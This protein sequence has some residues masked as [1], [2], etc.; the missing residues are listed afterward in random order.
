M[1]DTVQYASRMM[2]D[3]STET[4][5]KEHRRDGI[6]NCGT[7]W[8][9]ATR[10]KKFA[11]R[12]QWPDKDND[13]V[14]QPN[15][16]SPRMTIPETSR[17]LA[18]FSGR[19]MMQR[20]EREYIPRNQDVARWAETLTKVDRAIMGACDAEQ[21]DSAAF[22]DGPG[23]QGV[24]WV[25]W[26]VD[27][28]SGEN[29]QIK[30]ETVPIWS[31]LWPATREINLRDRAWQRWGS[32]WP[33]QTVKD[34]WPKKYDQIVTMIGSKPW[35]AAEQN[36]GQSSRIPWA[37]QAG[38]KPLDQ[39]SYYSPRDRAFWI[40]YEEWREL[41]VMV[42]VVRPRDPSMPYAEAMTY[43]VPEGTTPENDPYFERI[44]MSQKD[45]REWKAQWEAQHREQVPG[46][47]TVRKPRMQYKFAH[48]CGDVVLGTDDLEVGC[49]TFTAIAAEVVELSDR[50][51]YISLLEDL[52]D[53]QRMVN[54]MMSALIRDIQ[55]NPKGVL[56]VEQGLFRDK[57]AALT[58]FTAPG[59]VV[60]IPRGKLSQGAMP[61]RYEAGGTNAYSSKLENMLSFYREAIPRLAGFNPAALGQ[62][63]TDIRRVSGQVVRQMTD[64]SMTSN[65]ERVDGLRLY[66]REG[67][68]IFLAFLRMLYEP[69][70]LV[71]FIGE[72]DAYD[73]VLDPQT[74][75]P[76]MDPQTH[77]PQRVLAIPPKEMWKADSWKEI[78]IEE[79]AP[80]DDEIGDL[81]AKLQT[82][83]Q[84]L[85][86]PMT[87][88]GHPLFTSED[89]VE[90]LP[91]PATRRAK[92]LM[93]I[94]A[95]VRVQ[96]QA[97]AKAKRDQEKQQKE[98]A[99]QAQQAEADKAAADKKKAVA[100][101]MTFKDLPPQGQIQMAAEADIVLSPEDVGLP[102][103]T[104]IEGQA[105]QPQQ[106]TQ[107]QTDQQSGQP[108]Q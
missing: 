101:A 47:M 79:V 88:T 13:K 46:N 64:A 41:V 16:R 49:F 77:Q 72:E 80:S 97:Q 15:K 73:D 35:A 103:G 67:G 34:R 44:E 33:Q 104:P 24:S 31:M 106:P 4:M 9:K 108:G 100:Q 11:A 62:L 36:G 39:S 19:Q 54:F 58:A 90:L 50:T 37:G 48:A 26:Y 51:L 23:I 89:L 95:Q 30:V 3:P 38:N 96:L 45:A 53:A 27:E 6:A 32:W 63:G 25:R 8:A 78:A 21:V 60:E 83:V 10:L 107:P 102:P 81:W 40:E 12:Q 29:P 66:R 82:Q 87:D 71:D 1:A 18:T 7:F 5:L 57:D 99:Q 43:G 92:M 2:E 105:Q 94:R 61:Y 55:I 20:F 68:R 91:I 74:G 69:M 52:E 86:Q 17:V 22:R 56:F 98:Q 65:A 84:M 93:R 75:D 85:L 42:Q 70:D 76:V 14:N 28:W 59:G